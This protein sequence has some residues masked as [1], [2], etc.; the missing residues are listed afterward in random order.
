MCHSSVLIFYQRYMTHRSHLNRKMQDANSFDNP[1]SQT[2]L[3]QRNFGV[4]VCSCHMHTQKTCN[5]SLDFQIHFVLPQTSYN[6]VYILF[7]SRVS[8]RYTKQI[9][10]SEMN[11]Q[12]SSSSSVR[13]PITSRFA[14][15]CRKKFLGACFRP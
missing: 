11:K 12:E 1:L 8:S 3:G 13:N 2:S 6:I 9:S 7:F 10:L 14:F 5:L 4:I 15:K